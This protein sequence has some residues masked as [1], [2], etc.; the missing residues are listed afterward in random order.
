MIIVDAHLDLA[1]NALC[2]G[3]DLLLPLAELR[4]HEEQTRAPVLKVNGVATVTLPELRKAGVGLVLGSLFV[5]PISRVTGEHDG[6][7]IYENSVQ[8]HALA[9]EQLDYYRRLADEVDY[10]RLVT[11]RSIIDEIVESFSSETDR[12]VGIVPMMEGADAIREPAEAEMWFELGLRVIALAWDDTRYS[13]GAWRGVGGLTDDGR[14]LMEVM[15]DLGIILDLTHMSEEATLQALDSFEGQVIASHSNAR[16]I[17]GTQRQ[18]SDTQIRLIAERHGVIG[19]VLFN[20]FLKANHEKGD[21]KQAVSIK[22]LIAHIDHI[23]QTIGDANHVGIGSD[24]DGGFGAEDIPFELDT[25]S[26]LSLIGKGLI[27]Y[28]YD[29][30]DVEKIM[31]ANWLRLLES[32]LPD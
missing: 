16:S 32:S 14:R 7:F 2:H 4:A 15:A 5:A 22:Q 26:D 19:V 3:R 27:E 21:A 18:L 20:T 11:D 10:I 24:L 25:A 6:R 12:L 17:V 13:A 8:A 9:M 30:E 28:G 1:Y 31:G 23:C 29:P